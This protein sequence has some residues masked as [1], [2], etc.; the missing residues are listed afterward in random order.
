[1]TCSICGNIIEGNLICTHCNKGVKDVQKVREFYKVADKHRVFPDVDIKMPSRADEFSAGYDFYSNETIGIMPRQTHLFWTDIKAM[2]LL[3][4]FLGIYIRSSLATK[5]NLCLT[6]QVGIIDAS[7]FDNPE[8]GGNI[9]IALF[10]RNFLNPVIIDK[11]DRIAQGIFTTY[12][13][14]SNDN[15]MGRIRKG[16]FGSTGK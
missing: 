14:C 8:N 11:G 15:V 16:G 7:Y 1:M 12:Q 2:I 3:N 4:E 13:T 10:N 9:G 6:N 5:Y